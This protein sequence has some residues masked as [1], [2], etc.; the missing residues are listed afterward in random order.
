MSMDLELLGAADHNLLMGYGPRPYHWGAPYARPAYGGGYRHPA[1]GVPP[2]PQYG[3]GYGAPP[4]PYGYRHHHHHHHPHAYAQQAMMGLNPAYQQ[5][6]GDMGGMDGMEGYGGPTWF[7]QLAGDDGGGPPP[8]PHHG[9]HHMV[10]AH[11]SY[12]SHQI[13]LAMVQ[14]AVPGVAQRGARQQ[15]LGFS[16]G[17]FTSNSGTTLEVT[18][19]PQRPVRGGRV[20]G[21]YSRQ[22]TSSNGLLILQSLF[23]GTD[24]QLLSADGIGFDMIAPNT[25]GAGVNLT[26]AS[27]GNQIVATVT[28]SVAPSEEDQIPFSMGIFGL[29]VG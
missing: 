27:V 9:G 22:G 14:P 4:S 18:A 25:F 12:Y 2:A 29:T 1:Y 10:P 17:V 15:P 26:P 8:H 21:T 13:P 23:V 3:G 16:P 28:V 20:M 11:P 19:V 7:N 24:G 6:M 5:A